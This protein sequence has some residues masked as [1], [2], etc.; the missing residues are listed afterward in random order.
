MPTRSVNEARKQATH[1]AAMAIIAAEKK[2]RDEKTAKLRAAREAAERG[3]GEK[4]TR[5]PARPRG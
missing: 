3:A 2:K 5:T 4:P 1:D